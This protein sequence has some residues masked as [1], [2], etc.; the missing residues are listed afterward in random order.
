M[1]KPRR[2]RSRNQ[3]IGASAGTL[4]PPAARRSG[5]QTLPAL[6]AAIGKHIAAADGCHA[7]AEAVAALADQLRGLIRALHDILRFSI[8]TWSV[9]TTDRRRTDCCGAC[10]Q[11][12]LQRPAYRGMQGPASTSRRWR[13]HA[14][15]SVAFAD[16]HRASL[17]HSSF[18]IL[19]AHRR[20]RA[21]R[22]CRGI[23]ACRRTA[24]PCQL[25]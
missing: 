5:R 19:V 17:L 16:Q 10:R 3:K 25:W 14:H 18:A 11:V 12:P 15:N 22:P 24:M 4:A 7:G 21:P 2:P 6:G 13:S 8:K 20:D 23:E 1:A 9:P